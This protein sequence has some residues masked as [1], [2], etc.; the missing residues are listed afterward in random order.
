MPR[1]DMLL[2]V[3][4]I[5]GGAILVENGHRIDTSVPDDDVVASAPTD[6]TVVSAVNREQMSEAD[7]RALREKL[8]AAAPPE[9]AER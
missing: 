3:A 5:V 9:C 2:A 1:W 7:E 6:C 8:A 4:A